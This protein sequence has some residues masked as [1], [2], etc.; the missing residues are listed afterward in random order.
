MAYLIDPRCGVPLYLIE[1]K[2]IAIDCGKI[3]G[4]FWAGVLTILVLCVGIW[5]YVK[6]KDMSLTKKILYWASIVGIILL[7]WF[8][9]PS[10]LAWMNGKK[11]LVYFEQ[12]KSYMNNGMTREESVKKLQELYQTTMQANATSNAGIDIATALVASRR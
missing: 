3:S 11:W 8:V 2:E 9:N 6:I 4:Y 7:L 12:I 5:I 10:V 1:S